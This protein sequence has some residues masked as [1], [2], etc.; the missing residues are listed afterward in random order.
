MKKFA[1]IIILLLIPLVC[2]EVEDYNSYDELD[3]EVTISH[4]LDMI[5]EG[6]YS[7]TYV[8]SDLNFYPKSYDYQ[9]VDRVIVTD[10]EVTDQEDSL[11]FT[12]TEDSRKF[13]F[14]V[15]TD[16]NSKSYLVKVKEVSF[17]VENIDESV[18]EYLEEGNY[19]DINE[20]IEEKAEEIIQGEDDLYVAVF[21][22]A[23]WVENNIEYDLNTL[24]EDAVQPSSW[25]LENKEGVCDE[26][27][28]LFISF[29]RSLGIPARF[30]YGVAYTNLLYD[31]GP[32]G[33]AE[34]YIDGEWIPVDV[35]YGMIG[36]VDPSHI[37]FKDAADAGEISA[38]FEWQGQNLEFDVNQL[39]V[40]ADLV[41]AEGEGEKYVDVEIESLYESV[42]EGSYVPIQVTVTNNNDYYVP[43]KLVI[44]KAPSVV[45][46]NFQSVLLHPNEEKN[47]FW[48]VKVDEGLEQGLL[49]TTSIEVETMYGSVA[50]N[51]FNFGIANEVISKSEAEELIESLSSGEEVQISIDI[52]C[53]MEKGAYYDY[54]KGTLNCYSNDAD[55]VCLED[56]C[57]TSDFTWELDMADYNSQRYVVLAK[58]GDG[59]KYEYFDLKIYSEPELSMSI[60][61]TS[62]D[63]QQE[64]EITFDISSDEEIYN[65]VLDVG[66]YGKITVDSL[67]EES[68]VLPVA[69][70]KLSGDEIKVTIT[71]ED[72]L[73]GDYENEFTQEIEVTNIPFWNKIIIFFENLFS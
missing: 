51:E 27:T 61:P 37:K 38:H 40:D 20:D 13:D 19:I 48:I 65:V 14:E 12:W 31:F 50:S 25:V 18:A 72:A 9:S 7:I 73:G 71:Y 64:N 66:K 28:N 39:E 67:K 52:D 70:N 23:D 35:T 33:W 46:D 5:A 54:E 45:G 2:A 69:V 8:T 16:V 11:L 44:T 53:G 1:V 62:F 15:T 68:I 55:E 17:P 21:K 60:S 4:S 43:V 26:L 41:N 47:V 63:F 57:K 42:G 58:K 3:I 6:S 49:Y 22:L 29:S 10:A 24:T 32:H 59:T 36:W 34:V 30:V 56:D